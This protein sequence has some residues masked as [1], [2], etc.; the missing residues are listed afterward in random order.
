MKNRFE[1]E[2]KFVSRTRF[3]WKIVPYWAYFGQGKDFKLTRN[4]PKKCNIPTTKQPKNGFNEAI[5]LMSINEALL[6]RKNFASFK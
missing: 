5:L 2:K 6:S 4:C 1:E 3:F